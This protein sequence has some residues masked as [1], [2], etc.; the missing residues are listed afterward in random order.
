MSVICSSARQASCA[1]C[2]LAV[3]WHITGHKSKTL[4]YILRVCGAQ[5]MVLVRPWPQDIELPPEADGT[6]RCYYYF[7]VAKKPVR[8]AQDRLIC[9]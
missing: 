2:V 5:N 8:F 1:N 9:W 3:R 7:G 4:P 6:R